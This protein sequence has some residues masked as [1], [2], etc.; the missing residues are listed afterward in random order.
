VD[1]DGQH[2]PTQEI[3]EVVGDHAEEQPHLVGPE[4]VTGKASPVGGGLAFLDPPFR[5]PALIV[6]ADNGPVRPGQGGDDEAHPWE[7]FAQV[8]LDLGDYAARLVPVDG[9]E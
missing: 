6:E 8:M 1:R 9:W 5:R 7:E 3:A 2:Q 4:A